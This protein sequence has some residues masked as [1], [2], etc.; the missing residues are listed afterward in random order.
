[1]GFGENYAAQESERVETNQRLRKR[2]VFNYKGE[3]LPMMKHLKIGVKPGVTD[4][5]RVHFEWVASQRIIVIGHCGR[6]LDL[7]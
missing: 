5:I 7:K 4:T 1:M 6:H 3:P 2:R